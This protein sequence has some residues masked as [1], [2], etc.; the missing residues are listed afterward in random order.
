MEEEGG[1]GGE[2]KFRD[3]K[4][5]ETG[6]SRRKKERGGGGGGLGKRLEGRKYGNERRSEEE[7]KCKGGEKVKI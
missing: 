4:E 2:E 7:D 6:I 5:G 3:Y 1:V